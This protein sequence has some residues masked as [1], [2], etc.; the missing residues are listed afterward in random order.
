MQRLTSLMLGAALIL[1]A[2]GE[3]VVT[4]GPITTAEPSGGQ[5]TTTV[6]PPA[7]TAPGPTTT[8]V[9]AVDEMSV[10][11]YFFL[12]D[13]GNARRPGPFLVPV[14]RSVPPSVGVAK[15]A[16]EALLGGPTADE[17]EADPAIS[18]EIP[19]TTL[20]IGIDVEDG[21]ATV[22]LTG[23]FE[24]GGGT[25]SMT[26][27]LAQV[28]YTLTQ[29]PTVERVRFWLD[30]Q[31]AT[32]FSGEGIILDQPVG[33]DDFLDLVPLV[34]VDSP[35]YGG[36]LDNPGRIAGVA[37]VFEAV[38]HLEIADADGNVIAQ[39]PY[40]MTDNGV[41]WGEFD[42]TI[43]YEVDRPQLGSLTVWDNSAETGEE[44]NGRIYPVW[45]TP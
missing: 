31:P 28:V 12:D 6:A 16:M 35:T 1:A 5:P 21:L 45:L 8:T 32:V 37:A 36:V 2:C 13:P 30:G 4:A 34:M 38:F 17:L 33:R 18:S 14:H 44:Q 23:D 19:P 43:P 11:A 25:F 24:T 29:F 20:L 42:V 22:D 26:G 41:G 15:A 3:G 39:P 10:T 40:V 7:T 27:R 9:P